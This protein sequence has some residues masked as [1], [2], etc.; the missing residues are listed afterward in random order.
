MKLTRGETIMTGTSLSG[1]ATPG[2]ALLV[3][4]ASSNWRIPLYQD[5]S[6]GPIVAAAITGIFVLV[7]A[8]LGF[9]FTRLCHDLKHRERTDGYVRMQQPTAAGTLSA[10]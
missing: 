4:A 6:P 8:F 2:I 9:L 10:G 7:G 3:T 5:Q 1:I